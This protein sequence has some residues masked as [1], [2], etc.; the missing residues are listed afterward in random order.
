MIS[1]PQY[2][3]LIIS[4]PTFLRHSH[5]PRAFHAAVQPQKKVWGDARGNLD[6]LEGRRIQCNTGVEIIASIMCVVLSA[7]HT[8]GI[9]GI[10]TSN[11]F[12]NDLAI[13]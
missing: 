4:P 7:L 1:L 5:E 9:G 8:S 3:G 12:Q 2:T 13:I 10:G 11:R 6:I